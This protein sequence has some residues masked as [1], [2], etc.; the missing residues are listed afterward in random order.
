MVGYDAND[1][2]TQRQKLI[3]G[4]L[5]GITTKFIVQP[6]DVIK[7]RSQLLGKPKKSFAT[8]RVAK[9]ILWEEGI[10]AFW[11][12]HCLGQVLQVYIYNNKSFNSVT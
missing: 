12:G 5:T 3:V 6:M 10:T 11:Q 7:V 9:R 1:T 2:L 8:Y 4:C